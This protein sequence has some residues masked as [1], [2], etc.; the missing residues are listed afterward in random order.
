[1]KICNDCG[2]DR[3]WSDEPYCSKCGSKNLRPDNLYCPKC[4]KYVCK[5]WNACTHC[6]FDLR[7]EEPKTVK[8]G[9]VNRLLGLFK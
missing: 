2:K 3:L 1:M 5:H 9:F 6:G 8:N 4:Q 7:K